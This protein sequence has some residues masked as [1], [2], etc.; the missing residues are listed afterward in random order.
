MNYF[1]KYN[2]SEAF[3]QGINYVNLKL[4]KWLKRTHKK[5]KN[6]ILK[7]QVLLKRIAKGK[8]D[9]FYHWTAGYMLV[10]R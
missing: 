9:L 2:P 10:T 3:R 7:A 6:G 8:P 4:A 5:V 1:L